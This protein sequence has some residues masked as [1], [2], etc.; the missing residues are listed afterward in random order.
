MCFIAC[1][2]WINHHVCQA[3][4]LSRANDQYL[5]L[6]IQVSGL[7]C[8]GEWQ[9]DSSVEAMKLCMEGCQRLYPVL[10]Q[11]LLKSTKKKVPAPVPE[12][13]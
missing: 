4:Q 6:F 5:F 13:S 3:A 2:I 10:Q 11:S 1:L 8:T 12:A 9:G 7:L